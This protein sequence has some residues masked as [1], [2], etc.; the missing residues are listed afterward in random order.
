MNNISRKT[1]SNVLNIDKSIPTERP[2]IKKPNRKQATSSQNAAAA[3]ILAVGLVLVALS[4]SH[5]AQGIE[6]VT[7]S[8]PIG[9]CYYHLGV[10]FVRES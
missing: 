4:L 9:S 10:S 1:K 7:G 3:G 2:K 5:L 6:L 8:G